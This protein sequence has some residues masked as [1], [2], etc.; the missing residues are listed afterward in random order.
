MDHGR[1]RPA[2]MS[3]KTTPVSDFLA[4]FGLS[5]LIRQSRLATSHRYFHFPSSFHHIALNPNPIIPSPASWS[6]AEIEGWHGPDLPRLLLER[7][8]LAWKL[9]SDKKQN[10]RKIR[11]A[12]RLLNWQERDESRQ[13]ELSVTHRAMI[14]I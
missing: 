11:V 3:S 4:Q 7:P 13:R 5:F 6:P 8:E 9:T 1:P 10:E 12:H 14:S 2:L